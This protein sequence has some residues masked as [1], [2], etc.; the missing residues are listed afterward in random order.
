[1]ANHPDRSRPNILEY[2]GYVGAYEIC[3]LR[4]ISRNACPCRNDDH[5][6]HPRRQN[7]EQALLVD[8]YLNFFA[9]NLLRLWPCSKFLQTPLRCRDTEDTSNQYEN[10]LFATR[11]DKPPTPIL[12]SKS[13]PYGVIIRLSASTRVSLKTDR[14]WR[15]VQKKPPLLAARQIVE[16]SFDA[17]DQSHPVVFMQIS[18]NQPTNSFEN[19]NV[20]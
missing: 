1:M 16:S 4:E 18:A 19:Q 14:Y 6:Y 3:I 20:G 8:D 13:T 15:G 5:V 11:A 12:F 17:H 2:H 9:D 7:G 10:A